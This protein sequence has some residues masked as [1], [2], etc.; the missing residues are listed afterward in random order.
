MKKFRLL[1]YLLPLLVCNLSRAQSLSVESFRLLENDLTANTYGTMEY[2]QN[3]NVAA[4]IKVVTSETGFAFD[5]GMLGIVKT[6]QRTGEIW[7]YVPFG[8]QRITIAHQEFGVLRDYY[9]PVIIERGRTYE[10]RLKTPPRQI[11]ETE[12]KKLNNIIVSFIIPTSG[13]DLYIDGYKIG[14]GSMRLSV[15]TLREY[16]IE[17][18]KEGYNAYSA[19]F[20]F[21]PDEEGKMINIPNLTPVTGSLVVNS[22]PQGAK[23]IIGGMTPD[24]TP[25]RRD[26][27]KLGLYQIQVKNKGYEPFN[28]TIR[29]T[30]DK[31][32]TVDAE[33]KEIM[34]LKKN[35]VY[36]GVGFVTGH[37]TCY[38]ADL[39]FY[40]KFFNME[41]EFRYFTPES[42]SIYWISSPDNWSG[43]SSQLVYDYS[44]P[45]AFGGSVGY[46][47]C[48][49][50]KCRMTPQAGVLYYLLKGEYS[51]TKSVLA[52]MTVGE[53]DITTQTYVFSGKATGRLELSLIK[54][55]SITVCP[56]YEIP[57]FMGSLAKTIDDNSDF[58]KEH[59]GGFSVKAGFELYF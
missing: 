58:V 12:V 29:I 22:K 52:G 18:M 20:R 9:F 34:Y 57:V 14:T 44:T 1:L 50:K 24:V 2:D 39:G 45:M 54:G 31:T 49:G 56:S 46:S 23:V 16:K 15:E 17:V 59:C 40:H 48:I 53:D 8:L 3:G 43:A 38:S 30:E 32:Y 42:Q 26:S 27:L 5:A 21:E 41:G 7:V 6:T 19:T 33:L 11:Q 25:F 47:I 35:L 10:M 51:T 37:S 55:L 13:A 28:K 36:F 4:L